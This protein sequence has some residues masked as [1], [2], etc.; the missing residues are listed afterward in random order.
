MLGSNECRSLSQSYMAKA[1][2]KIKSHT[3]NTGL[4]PNIPVCIV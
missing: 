2:D 1:R 4:L 3:D